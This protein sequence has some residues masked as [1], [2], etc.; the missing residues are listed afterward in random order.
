M[1]HAGILKLGAARVWAWRYYSIRVNRRRR[2]EVQPVLA[3]LVSSMMAGRILL[4]SPIT[5]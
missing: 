5:A 2:S 3:F 1:A 4:R